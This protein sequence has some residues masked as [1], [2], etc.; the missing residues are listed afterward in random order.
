MMGNAVP[1]IPR[2]YTALAEWL[3]CGMFVLLIGPRQKKTPFT[4]AS[5]VYLLGII[6][7]MELN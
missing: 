2:L 7:F 4:I 1:D 3:S 6:V 5:V